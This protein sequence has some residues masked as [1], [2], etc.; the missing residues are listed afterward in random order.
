MI[1]DFIEMKNYEYYENISLKKY[2]SYKLDVIAKYLIF[3]NNED[4]LIELLIFIR[5]NNI[6]YIV[7]GNGS[8]V[9]FAND[10]YDG[11]VIRLDK[12]NNIEINNKIIKVGAGYSLTKLAM[13]VSKM[14]LSGLEFAVGIPGYVGASVAMNA[15][16]Y[17]H[18]MSE[19]VK[20]VRVINSNG[21]IDTFDRER[22]DFE[23]RDSFFKKNK[24]Y[25]I[26][27]CE[28]SLNDGDK[29]EIMEK[30]EKRKIRRLESQPLDYPSA[31]SVFRNPVGM[32]AGK[33]IEDIGMK[34]YKIGGAMISLKHANFIINYN[35][36]TGKD[37]IL[38]IDMIKKKVKEKYDIDLIL[39]QIIVD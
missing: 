11:V 2:N 29:E 12:I 37:I 13:E 4:E 32:Y 10:Y 14:G 26:V 9:I 25:I 5:D 34:G 36:A 8:N 21:E 18:S 19:I 20:S 39:E 6:K 24:D 23:Y 1:K 35:N 38:L 33:I 17:T 7:L 3:P 22:I 15:G 28:L 16:A 31:G 27:S 30:I